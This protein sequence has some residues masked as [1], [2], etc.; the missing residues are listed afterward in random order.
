MRQYFADGFHAADAEARGLCGSSS[1]TS[2]TAAAVSTSSDDG[3]A[4]PAAATADY[5]FACESFNP[6]GSLVKVGARGGIRL[7]VLGAK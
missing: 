3:A 6:T 5:G 1:S 4:V 7:V 2:V